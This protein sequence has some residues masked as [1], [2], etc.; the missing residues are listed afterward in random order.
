MLVCWTCSG[1]FIFIFSF[2]L[3]ICK[4][5]RNWLH[6]A[7]KHSFRAW[8]ISIYMGFNSAD[9]ALHVTAWSNPTFHMTKTVH[10]L[11][12]LRPVPA[13]KRPDINNKNTSG[14]NELKQS[15]KNNTI[16]V[17][18][19]QENICPCPTLNRKENSITRIQVPGSLTIN[20]ELKSSAEQ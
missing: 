17:I 16:H 15:S 3:N 10:Q 8:I 6:S 1:H 2:L 20:L 11:L 12:K 9:A 14:I 19:R 5:L 13:Q 7:H 4:C 18:Y